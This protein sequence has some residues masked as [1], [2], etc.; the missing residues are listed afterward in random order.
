[1]QVATLT[2]EEQITLPKPVQDALGVR[3]GD[4]IRF[5]ILAD[6]TVLVRAQR[7]AKVDLLSLRGILKPKVGG[8]TIEEMNETIRK[9][10]GSGA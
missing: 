3:P 10:G 6:G 5:E 9:V 8:V 4:Q 7:A 1:M 2:N